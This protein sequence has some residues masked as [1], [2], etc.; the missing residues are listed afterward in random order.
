MRNRLYG[1]G[2]SYFINSVK[3]CGR[4]SPCFSSSLHFVKTFICE[5]EH[6]PEFHSFKT[7][8][9][10][11]KMIHDEVKEAQILKEMFVF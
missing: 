9:S 7:K 5:E 11:F 3:V 8:S 1:G 6:W 10:V 2:S 4:Q